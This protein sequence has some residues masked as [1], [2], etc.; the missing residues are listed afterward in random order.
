MTN[1]SYTAKLAGP[2]ERKLG[3]NPA[4]DGAR[5]VSVVLVM[6]FHF[7]GSRYLDGAPILV[8][9]FFML[10]GFLITT[11]M[12]EERAA[13][14]AISLRDF[15]LRRVFRLFPAVYTLLAVF[16]VFALLFGGAEREQYVIEFLAAAF[17]VYDFWIAWV[18]VEGQALVQLW[19]LSLEEQFYFVCPLLLI[20]AMKAGKARRMNALL[21]GMFAVVIIMPVLRMTLTPELGGKTLE[22]F[23]FGFSILRP[24]SLV[25]GCLV[26]MIFR[27]DPAK[28]SAALQRFLPIGGNIALV[29]FAMTLCLGGFTPFAP[30]VS[31]FYNLTVIAMALWILDLVRRPEAKFASLLALP[32]CRWFG[33]RSYGI[34]IWHLLIYFVI[35]SFFEN[36][37]VGRPKLALL[38]TFPIAF[39]V[40]I[41]VS[42]LSWNY[43]ETPALKYK[44]RFAR[45][46]K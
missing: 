23:I 38:V 35:L 45:I 16:L 20:G 11:L 7:M 42:V 26:A 5:G 22:S 41:G 36:V 2:T 29:M 17:Y 24:D 18:G 6:S 44:E 8:D 40:T 3:W 13:R 21:V 10:S 43:V 4:L 14:G 9:M 31:L 19:T 15:Y 27:L 32:I 46:S 30:F 34:Y 12:F 33:K 37:F 25:L 28:N 39:A 1:T